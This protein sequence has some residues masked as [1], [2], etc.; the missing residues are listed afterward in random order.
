M[1]P[2]LA[3]LIY[4]L[5]FTGLGGILATTIVYLVKGNKRKDM[6]YNKPSEEKSNEDN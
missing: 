3:L 5:I 4:L 1:N 2:G 6:Y